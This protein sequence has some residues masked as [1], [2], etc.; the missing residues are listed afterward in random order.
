MKLL[1]SIS[2]ALTIAVAPTAQHKKSTPSVTNPGLRQELLKRVSEDQRI[3]NELI[4]KGIDHP[5]QALLD[6]MK[7]IDAS[8]TARIKV[9][10]KR[11]GWPGRKLIGQDGT[12]AFFLLAQH[13]DAAFQKK[14]FPLMQK[15]YK[16]GDLN[17]QNYALFTDRVLVASGKSQIYGTSAKPFAQW[18]G[19]EPTFYPIEDEANVDKRRAEVGLMPLSEYREFLKQMYFPPPAPKP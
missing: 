4:K 12:D 6:Q 13:A 1:L 11:Y 2:L 3:R 17:G 8:N 9:I 16:R 7:K 14:V 18:N 10:I 19:K 5:D 15:A